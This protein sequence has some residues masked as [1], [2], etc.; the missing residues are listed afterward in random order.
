MNNSPY[1]SKVNLQMSSKGQP[2]IC[3]QDKQLR[4]AWHMLLSHFYQYSF[5]WLNYFYDQFDYNHYIGLYV[6]NTN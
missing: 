5:I 4:Y 2:Y 3:I 6:Y 1:I